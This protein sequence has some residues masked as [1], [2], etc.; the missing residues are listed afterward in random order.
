MAPQHSEASTDSLGSLPAPNGT[1]AAGHDPEHTRDS[2]GEQSPR[3]LTPRGQERRAQLMDYAARRFAANGYHPTSV[4]DVVEGCGV[5]KGVFYW[6]F[7]SKEALMHQILRDGNYSLRRRQQA[8]LR[9]ETDPIKRLELG[10]HATMHWYVENRHMVNLF[11]FAAS[12][13]EFAATLRESQGNGLSDAMRHVKEAMAMGLIREAD[14]FVLT[15][16]LLGLTSHMV[17]QFLINA[18]NDPDEVAQDT[19]DLLF[20]GLGVTRHSPSSRIP[21]VARAQS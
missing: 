14:P 19:I 3:P 12:E 18:D 16:G 11:Q 20:F 5:G 1:N 17:R 13:S 21:S 8:A 10:M 4:A 7:E 2:K 6:Y 15:Q 9:N